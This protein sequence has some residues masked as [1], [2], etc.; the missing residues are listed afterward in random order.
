M[1]DE[2]ERRDR[3]DTVDS[4]LVEYLIVGVP[5]LDSLAD[6]ASALVELV[7]AR[8]IRILDLV[9]VRTAESGV[10]TVL[11]LEEVDSLTALAAADGEV[12]GLLSEHDT[13]L[14]SIAVHPGTAAIVLLVEDRWAEKLAVA[15]RRA[16]GR[17]I[18]GDRVP[19][20]NVEIAVAD[21]FDSDREDRGDAT[22]G[23]VP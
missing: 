15:A 9:V 23:E 11:E 13:K 6:V 2:P 18:G 1:T 4:D 17:I 22:R 3:A 5:D 12:G 14:A 20:P 21:T 7:E 16:G 8:A 19:R 10:A